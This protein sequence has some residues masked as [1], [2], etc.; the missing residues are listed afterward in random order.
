MKPGI[1]GPGELVGDRFA[2]ESMVRAGGGQRVFR[3]R[4]FEGG[5]LVALEVFRPV[6][7]RAEQERFAHMAETLAAIEHPG[8]APHVAHGLTAR[9]EPFLATEWLEGETLA[10]RWV[11]RPLCVGE[12]LALLRRVGEALALLHRRGLSHQGITPDQLFLR[13]GRAELATVFGLGLRHENLAEHTI[14]SSSEVIAL[15]RYRPPEQ[16]RGEVVLGPGVDVYALGCVLF[17]CL[18]GVSPVID[19]PVEAVLA[20]IL[21]EEAPRLGPLRPELPAALAA[22]VDRMLA[23]QPSARLADGAALVAALGALALTPEQLA[24]L[25]DPTRSPSGVEVEQRPVCLILARPPK[26]VSNPEAAEIEHLLEP[27]AAQVERLGEEAFLV[28]LS[29]PAPALVMSGWTATDQ[30]TQAVQAARALKAR[31]PEGSMA[32]VTGRSR[33]QPGPQQ[34]PTVERAAWLLD[35]AARAGAESPAALW[36]DELTAGLLDTRFVTRVADAQ[37][38]A[39]VLEHERAGLDEVRPLLGRPTP[40]VGRQQELRVLESLFLGGLDEEVAR[41]ALV[42]GA[43]GMGKSRLRQELVRRLTE[44]DERLEVLLGRGD[45]LRAGTAGGLWADALLGLCAVREVEDQE[46]RRRRFAARMGQHLEAAARAAVVEFLGELCDLSFPDQ[47]SP[48]LR[49][50]RQ[51]PRLMSDRL[52][53]ALVAFLRAECAAHPVLLVLEDLHWSDAVTVRLVETALVELG[54]APLLVLGLGRP[55]VKEQFPRLWE[56]G[57]VHELHLGGLSRE[58]S[59]RLV[60][61]M[62]GAQATPE[63]CARLVTQAGGNPLFLEELIRAASEGT[64]APSDTLLAM[65]QARFSRLEPGARRLLGAASVFGEV[66][67]RGGLLVLLGEKAGSGRE[68]ERSVERNIDRWLGILIA[69]EVVVR[70]GQGRCRYPGEQ[71]FSFRHGLLRDAAYGLL[72]EEDRRLGHRLAAAYLAQ[73]GEQDPMVLAEHHERGREGEQAARYLALGAEAALEASDFD[74][75]LRSVERAVAC[76]AAGEVLGTLRAAEAWAHLW[77]WNYPAAYAMGQASLAL[78]SPGSGAW[79]QALGLVISLDGAFGQIEPLLARIRLLGETTP[80]PGAE[81]KAI[82]PALMAILE[83]SFLGARE[84]SSQLLRHTEDICARLGESE[85]RARGLRW[86]ARGFFHLLLDGAAW[87]AC[88]AFQEGL[89]CMAPT[90][91]RRYVA[92]LQANMGLALS[93]LGEQEAARAEL[94]ACLATLGQLQE[95]AVR[96]AALAYRA[97]MMAEAAAPGD[98]EQLTAAQTLA[99]EMIAQSLTNFW[100]LMA[101]TAVV[102]AHL[103]RGAAEAAAEAARRVTGLMGPMRVCGVGARGLLCE[104]LLAQSDVAAAVMV[105]EEGLELLRA[106]GGTCLLDVRLRLAAAEA[107]HAAGASDAA[108]AQLQAARRLIDERAAEIPDPARRERFLHGVRDHARVAELERVW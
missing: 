67:W 10:E 57:S 5:R 73:M 2:I 52:T 27:Y 9:R 47:H 65:L 82:E 12:S 40:Y 87:R 83:T 42:L 53:A 28:T 74:G 15:L 102:R 86:L 45:P 97:F 104:S 69:A 61:E 49:A 11:T 80:W 17:Q 33:S 85:A 60:R 8:L 75:V 68:P 105:A 31:W 89:R 96:G 20:Q 56:R 41:A 58:A 62:L 30:A 78:L 13:D 46:E 16:A 106:A 32:L 100:N 18:T 29:H 95:A 35:L 103:A 1:P 63:V 25:P 24:L 59:E 23:K 38:G 37:A 43:S 6:E 22:L 108:H 54:E 19:G 36:L 93:F 50:A 92:I 44:R 39:F 99:E 72:D 48:Q 21:Y 70:S 7:T 64:S 77:R 79:Y 34:G 81:G 84:L 91:D 101:H 76:G 71:E 3:A 55:E 26:S 98:R 107:Y 66:F 90:G 88:E 14:T 51:D 94:E 4:D